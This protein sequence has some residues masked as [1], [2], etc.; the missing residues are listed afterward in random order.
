ME[1][2]FVS[3]FLAD[4]QDS[5]TLNVYGESLKF[6]NPGNPHHTSKI[7][8]ISRNKQALLSLTDIIRNGNKE[9]AVKAFEDLDESAK[10]KVLPSIIEFIF[11]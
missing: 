2:D 7:D 8:Q 6:L 5:H 11:V 9:K 3:L 4:N 1:L 10:D